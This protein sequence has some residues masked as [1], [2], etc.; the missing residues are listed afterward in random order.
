MR[1]HISCSA[2][3]SNRYLL[4]VVAGDEL[5]G[6]SAVATFIE[7]MAVARDERVSEMLASEVLPALVGTQAILDAYWPLL[8]AATRRRLRHL[9]P[10]PAAS[11][12][13]PS[14]E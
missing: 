1:G 8:G 14:S 10:R 9:H 13:F 6:R 11:V 12:E 2:S 5:Q 7:D 3:R 4:D